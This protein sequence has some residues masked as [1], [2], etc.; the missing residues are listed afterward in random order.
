MPFAIYGEEK[1]AAAAY[2]VAAAV[3][4][5]VGGETMK[6]WSLRRLYRLSVAFLGL[7]SSR[8]GSASALAALVALSR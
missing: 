7:H 5:D 1:A 6:R 8:F 4:A 3:V 2:N